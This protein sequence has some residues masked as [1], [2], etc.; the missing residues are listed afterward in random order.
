[1][2]HATDVREAR[3]E[4]SPEEIAEALRAE[5]RMIASVS[6]RPNSAGDGFEAALRLDPI[7]VKGSLEQQGYPRTPEALTKIEMRRNAAL[8]DCVQRVNRRLGSGEQI[9][10]FSVLG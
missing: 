3:R 1:V 10:S 9:K 8:D 4:R 6:L 2:S 5:W 7:V